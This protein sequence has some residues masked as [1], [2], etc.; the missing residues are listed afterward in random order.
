M[1]MKKFVLN[2]VRALNDSRPVLLGGRI[3]GVPEH[4]LRNFNQAV[5]DELELTDAG[6]LELLWPSRAVSM[7]I[8]EPEGLLVAR[9]ICSTMYNRLHMMGLEKRGQKWLYRAQ[10]YGRQYLD[11]TRESRQFAE[12]HKHGPF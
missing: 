1:G 9:Y 6:V 12:D 11:A 5:F 7:V 3:A 2:A 8:A 10:F 4:V